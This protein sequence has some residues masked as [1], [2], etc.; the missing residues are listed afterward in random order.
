MA[1]ACLLLRGRY[2][3][4][5]VLF[6]AAPMLLEPG[7]AQEGVRLIQA[8]IEGF[9]EQ[10]RVVA[11]DALAHERILREEVEVLPA[12]GA[13]FF[14]ILEANCSLCSRTVGAMT[15]LILADVLLVSA[16]ASGARL[17]DLLLMGV[18]DEVRLA[19]WRHGVGWHAMVATADVG[20]ASNDEP[21]GH[22][23][24][25]EDMMIARVAMAADLQ[26]V[27][28]ATVTCR[29]GSVCAMAPI[30]LASV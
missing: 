3:A 18:A 1:S 27:Q 4:A 19:W 8:A 7:P 10:R 9:V 2:K 25:I 23:V 17:A 13:V 21:P 20:L 11:A 26:A 14:P 24:V 5:N 30:G 29:S 12:T 22:Q 6:L 28:E 15:A 16:V